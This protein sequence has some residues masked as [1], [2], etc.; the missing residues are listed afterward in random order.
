MFVILGQHEKQLFFTVKLPVSNRHA[1]ALPF[2]SPT[3]YGM[4]KHGW[5]TARFDSTDDI[6]L[7]MLHE[8]ID[9]SFRAVAPKTVLAKLEA[10]EVDR[11]AVKRKSVVRKSKRPT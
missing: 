1:L 9:E 7:E 5:V 6:P 2:T 11:V 10:E 3:E 8:W 4:G